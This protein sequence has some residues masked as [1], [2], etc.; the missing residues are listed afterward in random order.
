MK[1]IYLIED[2]AVKGGAER[3][4]AQKAGIMASRWGHDVTI[5]SIYADDRP[6]AY[7]LN[8]VRLVSLGVPFAVKNSGLARKTLS[9]MRVIMQAVARFNKAADSMRPDVIF[10]TLSLGALILP[11]Y[12]GM[13]KKVYESHLARQFTPYHRFFCMMERKADA[14]VCLTAGDASQYRRSRNVLTIPNF[15]SMP[16]AA[17]RDYGARRAVAVG[18]LERAKGFDILVTLWKDIAADCPDWRLDIYGEGPL[19]DALQRQ[20]TE[21]GLDGKVR[22]CGRTERMMETYTEYS[23]HLMT[24]RFE[25]MPM[26]LVEAQACGLPSVT[27]DY[28]YGAREIVRHGITGLIVPQGDG[29]GFVSAVKKMMGSEQARRSYGTEARRQAA[30]F[31][32]DAVM[33]EWRR[34]LNSL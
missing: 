26:T 4:I 11:F 25:G 19:H 20:I 12:R 33:D 5:V 8:G 6:P 34:L 31:S 1:I 3:I 22:L 16:D 14:V 13:A 24:S 27:F 18:R 23:L 7:P 17:V 9:R 28:D 10:F 15:I 30:R 21:L 29:A 32:P 2:F